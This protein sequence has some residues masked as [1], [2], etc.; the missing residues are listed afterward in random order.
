MDNKIT[1]HTAFIASDEKNIDSF[2]DASFWA[3][4]KKVNNAIKLPGTYSLILD[5]VSDPF[6]QENSKEIKLE[7]TSVAA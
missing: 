4:R 3:L 1:F 6:V 7:D 2:L 5:I